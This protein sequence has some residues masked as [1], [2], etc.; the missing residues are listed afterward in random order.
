MVRK[1]DV[2]DKALREREDVFI[3]NIDG[4]DKVPSKSSRRPT[5]MFVTYHVAPVDRLPTVDEL[6]KTLEGLVPLQ[7][8]HIAPYSISGDKLRIGCATFSEDVGYTTETTRVVR[9]IT[10]EKWRNRAGYKRGRLVVEDTNQMTPIKRFTQV[11]LYPHEDLA[12]AYGK[13]W[14]A[15][16]VPLPPYIARPGQTTAPIPESQKGPLWK[17]LFD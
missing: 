4:A 17:R 12:V 5:G 8:D 10:D 6:Q 2:V 16:E 14:N 3:V 11:M 13:G 7:P 15:V 1:I 9:T